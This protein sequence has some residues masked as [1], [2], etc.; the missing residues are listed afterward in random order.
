MLSGT[1]GA[2]A[3]QSHERAGPRV[4]RASRLQEQ[5]CTEV[6]RG[7]EGGTGSVLGSGDVLAPDD[8]PTPTPSPGSGSHSS[9]EGSQI[10]WLYL[11]EVHHHACI[12][13]LS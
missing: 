4:S 12:L 1:A 13:G 6:A 10:S 9:L 3:D 11:R 7:P 5:T 2:R 8:P